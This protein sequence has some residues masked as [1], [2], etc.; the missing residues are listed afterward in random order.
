VRQCRKMRRSYL[1]LPLIFGSG[2]C[3]LAYQVAWLRQFRLLF[4]AST[5][6][7]AAV[8]AIFIGGLGIGSWVLGPRADKES[9]PLAFYAKLEAGIALLAALTPLTLWLSEQ[10]YLGLGG[11]TNL[12]LFGA[13]VVRLI[14][15]ALVLLP[16]TFLMGG[17]LPAAARALELKV[18]VGRES[19]ALLYGMNTFGAVT[20]AFVANFVLLEELG[21][22]GA[23]WLA[24][25]CN[26]AVAGLAFL[27]ASAS[28]AAAATNE[29][30]KKT[31]GSK[32]RAL[33]TEKVARKP[34]S[35]SALPEPPERVVLLAAGVVGFAFFLMEIVWYR[36][37]SPLLGGTVFSM[38]LVLTVALFG[39]ALGGIGYA[40][41]PSSQRPTLLSLSWT[42]VLEACL[43]VGPF[44]FGDDIALWAGLLQNFS[45]VGFW[46]QVFGW[47]AIAGIVILPGAIV[48]GY[49]FPLLIALLGQGRAGVGR[50]AGR[51]YAMNTLGAVVG[52]LSG[53]FGLMPL[54]GAR[55]CWTAVALSLVGLALTTA[56][57]HQL[58]RNRPALLMGPLVA[59]ALALTLIFSPGPSTFWR[60]SGIGIGRFHARNFGSP[61]D[62][63]EFKNWHR[64]ALL[65]EKD[66]VESGVALVHHQ[67]M[68]FVVNGKIDGHATLDAPTQIMSGLLGSLLHPDPKRALV[69]GLGTGST[70]G[71]LGKV[72]SMERVDVSELESAIYQVARDCHEVNHDVLNN[73]K[74]K[75]IIGDGRELLLT[76]DEKYD[77]IFSEPSNPYRAGIASFFTHEF[78]EATEEVLSEDGIF[79]Q[80]IQAYEIN[81]SAIELIYATLGDTFPYIETWRTH[82]DLLLLATKKPPLRDAALLKQR[83]SEEPYKTGLREAWRVTDL[84]SLFS[85]YIAEPGFALALNE[86]FLGPRNTD[87]RNLLEFDFARSVGRSDLFEVRDALDLARELKLDRPVDLRDELGWGEVVGARARLFAGGGRGLAANAPLDPNTRVSLATLLDRAIASPATDGQFASALAERLMPTSPEEA[88]IVLSDQALKEDNPSEALRLLTEVFLHHRKDPWIDPEMAQRGIRNLST[89]ATAHPRLRPAIIDLLAQPFAARAASD[90]RM[91]TLVDVTT[92]DPVSPRCVEALAPFEPHA[93]WRSPFLQR[94]LKCYQ[95]QGHRLFSRAKADLERFDSM[96]ARPFGQKLSASSP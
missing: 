63:Q 90:A 89:L 59:S 27:V 83:I 44:A 55:G 18:S 19:T 62:I 33:S 81:P 5:A 23:L 64:R 43:L 14:L 71:W 74:V 80:W 26:L 31:E 84:E 77:V 56:W 25:L 22:R 93:E 32:K 76:T 79:V 61:N 82:R 46:G 48:S 9:S 34:S 60:H 29:A 2:A 7:S 16:P 24:A 8:L 38:G 65:W 68:A 67:G 45:N 52:S 87:N 91:N 13:T 58:P 78:Y 6:A 70:A 3:A 1:I 53:G 11:S 36:V 49:Q 50:D 92:E 75:T 21:N 12:G 28:S 4:G 85:Y 37:L 20:G 73:S 86:K 42:C 94:R 72:E 47:S 15:A 41:R 66:G 95:T 30:R 96:N 69:I 88:K 51:A 35:G 10:A 57:R 17:T 54:L 40:L 39:V